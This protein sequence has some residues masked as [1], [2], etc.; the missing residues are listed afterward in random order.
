MKYA[1]TRETFAVIGV[2]YDRTSL[3]VAATNANCDRIVAMVHHR[4]NSAPIARRFA[5]IRATSAVT[6][7]TFVVT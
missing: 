5:P 6:V 4:R 2:T 1:P 7:A 3:N